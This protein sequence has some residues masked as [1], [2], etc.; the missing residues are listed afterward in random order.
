MKKQIEKVNEIVDNPEYQGQDI[1]LGDS[2]NPSAENYNLEYDVDGDQQVDVYVG[3]ITSEESNPN[4]LYQISTHPDRIHVTL[5]VNDQHA[6]TFKVDTG[7]DT[8]VLTTDDLQTFPFSIDIKPP[9]STLRGY[10][11]NPI[12]NIGITVLN[13]SFQDKSISTKFHIVNAPGKP[14]IL[15]CKQSQELDLIEVKAELNQISSSPDSSSHTSKS[16][17]SSLKGNLTE[18]IILEEYSD[19]FD[20][21]GR[22]PGDKYHITLIDNPTPVIH[23]LA[24]YLFMSCHYIKRNE[25][26]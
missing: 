16:S 2:Y 6:Q 20:K 5:K 10:S 26:E 14:S 15:G 25:K 12:E 1:Y 22:F 9:T 11:N 18:A 23:P 17:A 7:A 3:E 21:V 24:R 8:C 4:D 19:C 13:I